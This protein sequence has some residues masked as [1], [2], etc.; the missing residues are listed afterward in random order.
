MCSMTPK[1]SAVAV[2]VRGRLVKDEHLGLGSHHGPD[3]DLLLFAARKGRQGAADKM[4]STDDAQRPIQPLADLGAG[5]AAV[6][7]AKGHFVAYGE[8]AELGFGVLLHQADHFGDIVDG[9]VAY[10]HPGD[11][12]A[13]RCVSVEL[14]EKVTANG[15]RQRALAAARRPSDDQ[16]LP[17]LD[18]QAQVAQGVLLAAS[19]AVA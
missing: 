6:F 9:A 5:Q 8:G 11:G 1:I 18:L 3:G 16:E 12:D 15:Q 10:S 14:A 4:L 19:E 17:R 7:Q 13:A 2:Q